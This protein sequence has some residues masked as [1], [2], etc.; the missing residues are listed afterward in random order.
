[1]PSWDIH[2]RNADLT[3]TLDPLSRWSRLE[4]VERHNVNDTWRITG[5]EDVLGVFEPGMGCILDRDGEQITSGDVSGLRR[6]SEGG[7]RFAEV[8]FASDTAELGGSIVFPDPTHAVSETPSSFPVAY[9]VR[10][11]TAEAIMLGL[12]SANLGST[13]IGNRRLTGLALPVSQGRGGTTRVTGRFNNLGST[14]QKLAERGGLRVTVVHD[15]STGTPRPL[16]KI[17]TVADV[18]AN[19]RFGPADSTATGLIK[20]DSIELTRPGITRAIV[21][22]GGQGV[23][24]IIV[25]VIDEEA[26]ALWSALIG[27]KF[28][29]EVVIDQR[30]T[31][32]TDELL[33]AA[34][35]ALANGAGVVKVSFDV[36]DGP[37]VVYRRDY[38]IGYRVGVDLPGLPDAL[39]DNVVREVTTIVENRAGEP[40]EQI[41]VVVGTPD[42]TSQ[43]KTARQVARAL[44]RITDIE[45][46]A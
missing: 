46:S 17:D 28:K 36:V 45:R 37:D 1:V 23:N 7:R 30:Q 29:R 40:T 13:A 15:E 11:G 4:L 3:R 19:V 9:D 22:G 26:E 35:D 25:Q 42:A 24:R 44:R 14:V 39:S 6:W 43:S 41:S 31:T 38:G 34:H 12:I 10:T 27:K 18:A 8:T 5:P 20:N 32:D 2:P 16:L 33:A 21:L